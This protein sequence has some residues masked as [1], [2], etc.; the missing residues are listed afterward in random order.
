MRP[1]F[2]APPCSSQFR[3][4]AGPSASTRCARPA[5]PPASP[6]PRPSRRRPASPL[7]RLC[8]RVPSGLHAGRLPWL[9]SAHASRPVDRMLREPTLSPLCPSASHQPA[10]QL[11]GL[12]AAV[13]Q[14][15]TARSA[16]EWG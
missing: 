4:P 9:F 14:R 10:A 15:P 3:L 7:P 11:P 1:V 6:P 16:V 12:S 5:R 13:G 8:A 2:Y